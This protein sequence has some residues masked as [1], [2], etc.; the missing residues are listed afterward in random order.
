MFSSSLFYW[1]YCSI[2]I[3]QL[4]TLLWFSGLRIWHCH[5]NSLGFCCGLSTV[6]GP[7][8]STCWGHSQNKQT[9]DIPTCLLPTCVS[10]LSNY[11]PFLLLHFRHQFFPIIDV[12]HC[13]LSSPFIWPLQSQIFL[14]LSSYLSFFLP[15]F[16][17]SFLPFFFLSFYFSTIQQGGQIILTCIHYN[18]IIFPHPLFFCNMSI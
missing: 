7:G 4:G 5:C 16:L 15:S 14:F 8:T 11:K 9:K 3:Y 18:Y 13:I 1:S 6:P 2:K 17:P 12:M 10:F